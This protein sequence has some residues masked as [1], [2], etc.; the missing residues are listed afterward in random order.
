MIINIIYV[1][2]QCCIS[3][4]NIKLLFLNEEIENFEYTRS[5]KNEGGAI[6]RGGATIMGNTDNIYN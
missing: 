5:Q 6:I 2:D 3:Q 4:M 1:H